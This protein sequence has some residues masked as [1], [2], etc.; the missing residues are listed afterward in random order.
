LLIALFYGFYY[1][2]LRQTM[3]HGLITNREEATDYG[4]P[5]ISI[6]VPTHNE[7]K[8]IGAMLQN[9]LRLNYPIENIETIVVDGASTDET[10]Q[11]VQQYA[12]GKR[13]RLV[14]QESR[15]GWNSA[16]LEGVQKSK[17]NVI[18]LSGSEVFYDR[19]AMTRLCA[20]FADPQVGAVTGK[21]ILF[22]ADEDLATRMEE[23]YRRAQDFVSMAESMLD[24]PFDVKGE[25]VAVRRSIM[26]AAIQRMGKATRGSLDA[27][28]AFETKAQGEKLIFEPEATYSEYAPTGIQE[29][30]GMQVRRG[31]VLIESVAI[32]LW[33]LWKPRYGN[34]GMLIFPCHFVMLTLLPWVFFVGLASVLLLALVNPYYIGVL[35]L[36]VAVA[37]W[38]KWRMLLISFLLSQLSLVLA[39]CMIAT[40]RTL[41]IRRIDSTRRLP[42]DMMSKESIRMNCSLA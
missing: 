41:T 22:N 30:L 21:E 6:I 29:R 3:H 7:G 18:V 12:D 40:H 17:G 4:L 42:S 19:E 25:I 14:A 24:Q 28:V 10:R 37:F 32:Y 13:L 31:K 9:T 8:S 5:T 23:E 20:H 36:A 2:I 35:T 27:C 39:M 1:L 34:F 33:M 38:K 15:S 16:V 11:V 26:N